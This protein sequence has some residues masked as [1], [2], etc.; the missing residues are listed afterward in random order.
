MNKEPGGD[1]NK[2]EDRMVWRRENDIR[3]E[4]ERAR[5]ELAMATDRAHEAEKLCMTF[6]Q[7]VQLAEERYN[8]FME[9]READHETLA[10]PIESSSSFTQLEDDRIWESSNRTSHSALMAHVLSGKLAAVFISLFF[11]FSHDPCW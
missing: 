5:Q 6:E 4:L 2:E 1:E 9:K 8:D 10:P 7:R 3:S 11:W